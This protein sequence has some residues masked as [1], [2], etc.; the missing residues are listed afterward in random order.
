MLPP[1]DHR[2]YFSIDGVP[3]VAKDQKKTTIQEKRIKKIDLDLQKY[4]HPKDESLIN[5]PKKKSDGRREKVVLVEEDK[6]D[7]YEL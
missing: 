6:P 2:Y 7:Y 4:E 1:G 5:T 3:T